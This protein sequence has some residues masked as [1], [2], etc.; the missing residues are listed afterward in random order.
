[1][2]YP[3]SGPP[4]GAP[5]NHPRATLALVLGVVGVFCGIAAP[6]AL[7]IGRK[8]VTDID[9][10]GGQMGGRGLA[11]AGFILGIIG[12]VLLVIGLV[13]LPSRM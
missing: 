11:Q 6:F 2:A 13:T 9:A 4:A 10:S 12:T 3:Q 1:M 5:P 8:A 7:F